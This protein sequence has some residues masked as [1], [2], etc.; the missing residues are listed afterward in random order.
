MKTGLATAIGASLVM[1]AGSAQ[2]QLMNYGALEQLFGEP[3]TTSVTGSPQR[4]SDVPA[5]MEIVTADDIRRSGAT[6]IPGVLRHVAGIDVLQWTNDQADVSVR[7]YNQAY[8]PRLLVLIDGRQVY[9]DF[10][11]FTPWS[12]LPVELSAIR[13]I[14][15]VKGPNSAL[16]GFNAAGGVI[17]IV[18]YNPLYDDVN[19]ASLTGATQSFGQGSLVTT[20]KLGERG[21]VRLMVG[22]RFDDDF[23]TPAGVPFLGLRRD[24]NRGS[25]DLNGVVRLGEKTTLDLE[26]SHTFAKQ[27][28]VTGGYNPAFT[29]YETNSVKAQLT[30]DT[31]TGLWQATAY[32]NWISTAYQFGDVAFV[33]APTF[34]N[35][36]TVVQLQDSVKVGTD[37]TLRGTVEYRHNTAGTTPFGGA[38]V[39]YDVVAVGGM[40]QWQIMPSLALTNALRIDHLM[41]GR[42][43]SAPLGSPFANANWDRSVTTESFNSGL[44]WKADAEDTVRLTVGRGVQLPNLAE[45]GALAFNSPSANYTGVPTL[46]PTVVTNYELGWDHYFEALNAHFRASGF[47]Q[48]TNEIASLSGGFLIA[49]GGA[50]FTS[51]NVARS[52]AEGIELALKGKFLSDWR[53]GLSYTPEVV[54][55]RFNPGLTNLTTNVDFQHTNPVHVVNA[56]LG[57]SHGPWEIDGFLRY[58][59]RFY[60]FV[61][62]VAG[63]FTTLAPINDYVSIDGRIAYQ[64][65]DRIT[66]ALSGQN[67]TQATQRQTSAPNVERR[68]IGTITVK[69]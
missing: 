23:T 63:L 8:S 57:W 37:H 64:L 45:L 17:N 15:I 1:A 47:H 54:T 18:T 11:G 16:F 31:D 4:A 29:R 44:V 14:E 66:L 20:M 42:D 30:S 34:Q 69:F 67:I 43:G 2:G 28:E 60:G 61:P 46:Q 68:V 9:A 27:D 48:T 50:F 35:N 62:V 24:D 22:G 59:S 21:A 36:V 33:P 53:W 3:V 32:S 13:Q 52:H 39:F 10:Y 38:D 49:P 65:T 6:D 5:T 51:A 25:F 40:W 26:A 55:D 56:N 7:G 58:E 19:T 41:L 12:A